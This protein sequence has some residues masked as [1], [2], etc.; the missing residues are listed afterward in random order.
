MTAARQ[1]FLAAAGLLVLLTAGCWQQDKTYTFNQRMRVEILTPDGPVT[2]ENVAR[3]RTVQ[4]ARATMSGNIRRNLWQGEALA[5][6][7]APGRLL[8]ITNDTSA[9]SVKNITEAGG[10]P[11][12][13]SDIGVLL[14]PRP[15][16]PWRG[17]PIFVTFADLSDP[18]S[19]TL[20]EADEIGAVFGDGYA[21]GAVSFEMTDRPMTE[22]VVERYLPWITAMRRDDGP[23]HTIDGTRGRT[24]R[25]DDLPD[26][27]SIYVHW[28]KA[29]DWTVR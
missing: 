9:Y 24:A 12:R 17:R 13:P 3:M 26:A 22:G 7:L 8:F 16:P 20:L 19:A 5:M 21:L 4:F 18:M 28:L 14:D 6:E 15:M 25:R 23:S 2:G 1:W 27:G 11:D 29:W 10:K